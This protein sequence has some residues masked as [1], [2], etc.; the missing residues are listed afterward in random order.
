MLLS[1]EIFTIHTVAEGEEML[2]K[3]QRLFINKVQERAMRQV[4]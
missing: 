3:L 4:T 2:P 1:I